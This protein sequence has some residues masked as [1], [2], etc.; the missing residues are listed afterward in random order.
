M[1]DVTSEES[2]EAAVATTV[3]ELGG[4][5]VLVANAGV[6]WLRP[7]L[8]TP[9]KRWELCLRVNLTGVFLVTRAVLPHVMKHASGSLIAVTTSGV[10]MTD[11]GSNAY[12]VSKAGVERYYTGLANE[13]KDHNI[14]VNCLAPTK[15]V[16][17]EGW[18]SGGAGIE[19]PPEMVEAPEAMGLAARVP[20]RAGRVR[21]HGHG[22]VL[23]RTPRGTGRQLMD[24]AYPPEAEAFREEFR[25]WLEANLPEGS[26]ASTGPRTELDSDALERMRGA[27][28]HASP[29]PAT[30]RSPGPTEYGGRG[31]GLHGTGRVRRGD[32]PG[33]RAGH[34]QPDRHHQHRAGHHALRH[35]RSR[36]PAS[37]P[38]CCAATTSGA[39]AS[40]SPTP[41]PTSPR[42]AR[43]R[44][45][46]ATTSSST[47][48][49]CGPPSATSANWCE[50]LVRTDP[51]APK[52]NG[53]S[54]L[55]VDMTLPGHR[56]ASARH[57]HRRA[58]VQRDLLRRRARAR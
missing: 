46:T 56:G 50:L 31:A 58:R 38:A 49:R 43:A 51:E 26:S 29:T 53:I 42:C 20:G 12:W 44:C 39:R 3:R 30:P 28:T 18:A 37:C 54:C 15:V 47:G 17:T 55:L 7:T 27:G 16:L 57:D 35:R 10:G 40:P 19:V 25:A 52:H 34:P 36:R 22:A 13:M 41:V 45:A 4:I 11:L 6:M 8:D 14:A 24:F 2:V 21:H 23:A 33:R 1:C 5:D 9:L 32:E 48:R